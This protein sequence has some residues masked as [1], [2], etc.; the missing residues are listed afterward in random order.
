MGLAEAEGAEGGEGG[1]DFVDDVEGVAAGEGAGAEGL[2]DEV[3]LRAAEEAAVLVGAGQSAAGHDVHGA[4]DLFVE[5]G[6]PVGLGE[7]GPQVGVRVVGGCPAVPLFEE[8]PDHVGLHG[9]G[10]EEGDVHGEVVELVGGELADEFALARGLDLEAA[11]GVGGADH[12]VGGGVVEGHLFEVDVLARGAF[13]LGDRVGDGGLHAHAEDVE[14]EEAHG[15]HVVLVELAHGQAHAG[16]LDGGA[17]QQGGVA[18]DDA[19][20]VHGDVAGQAVEAFGEVDEQV[21][22]AVALGAAGLDAAGEA[23]EFGHALESLAEVRGGEAPEL[24]GD[25]VHLGFGHAEGEAGVADGAAGP[26]GV[27]HA[28]EG[29]ALGAEALDDGVVDL[30][31]AGGLHVDVDVR[32]GGAV[33]GEEALHDQAVGHGVDMGDA[34][35]VVDERG[36]AGAAGGHADAHAL[37]EVD[38]GG[39]GE[40]VGGE[41]ESGDDAELVFGAVLQVPGRLAGAGEASPGVEVGVAGEE[42]GAG[43]LAQ[44]VLRGAVDADDGGL[45]DA[46]HAPAE[47]G[48]GV[49]RAGLG[50]AAGG[51]EPGLSLIHI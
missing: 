36:G 47:V 37:D 34:Q 38:D 1:P 3:F 13:D 11:E 14:L 28:H 32:E 29:G 27:L 26:V 25:G 9:A 40:E 22:L 12:R 49:E 44:H 43:A 8:G 7:D 4:Q 45:G 6:D 35:G 5:D 10:A 46:G 2:F 23:A 15:V 39:H 20:G 42:A 16:G 30:V 51:L 18:E 41:A 21:Q 31:A 17:V 48:L 33:G 24:L 19:A 50:E